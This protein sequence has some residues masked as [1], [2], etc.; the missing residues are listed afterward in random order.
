MRQINNNTVIKNIISNIKKHIHL[1]I[2]NDIS[3]KKFDKSIYIYI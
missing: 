2:Y 1:F 3:L